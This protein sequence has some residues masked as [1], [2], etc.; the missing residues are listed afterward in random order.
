MTANPQEEFTA[1]F[2]A[3]QIKT[4]ADN[5]EVL[6]QALDMSNEVSCLEDV[7]VRR[8]RNALHNLTIA[9]ISNEARDG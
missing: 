1:D 8:I 2:L 7:A 6:Y 3:E 5:V 4:A 9:I